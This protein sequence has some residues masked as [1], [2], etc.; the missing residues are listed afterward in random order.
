[1]PKYY[2]DVY[3]HFEDIEEQKEKNEKKISLEVKLV[4]T[5]ELILLIPDK[6][7]TL[8]FLILQI[9]LMVKPDQDLVTL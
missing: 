3:N 4:M 2:E 8:F 6:L 1:M 7:L 9:K 5:K